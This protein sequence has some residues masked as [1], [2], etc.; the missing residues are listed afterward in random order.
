LNKLDNEG[1]INATEAN[2]AKRLMD[3]NLDMYTIEG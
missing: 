3:D 1:G 2:E